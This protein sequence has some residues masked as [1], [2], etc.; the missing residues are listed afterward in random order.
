MDKLRRFKVN[1]SERDNTISEL[2]NQISKQ[3]RYIYSYIIL[4]IIFVF[5]STFLM[6]CATA[7]LEDWRKLRKQMG[8]PDQLDQDEAM[9]SYHH[10]LELA[11]SD[12]AFL[13]QR[14][15]SL[16]AER[17][18]ILEDLRKQMVHTNE[19]G[20]KF[21]GISPEQMNLVVQY[22]ESL[23]DGTNQQPL[24][25][26]SRALA[27]QLY[28]TLSF[29]LLE[30][31]SQISILVCVFSDA[32]QESDQLRARIDQLA[33]ERDVLQEKLRSQ[34]H[35][36]EEKY[37]AI[38][39][40]LS[41]LRSAKSD[42]AFPADMTRQLTDLIST[43]GRQQSSNRFGSMAS[44]PKPQMTPRTPHVASQPSLTA[45]S[46]SQFDFQPSA[47]ND[48]LM[49]RTFNF[50]S[51]APVQQPAVGSST[52]TLAP[53]PAPASNMQ[54]NQSSASSLHESEMNAEA[55]DG[56]ASDHRLLAALKQLAQCERDLETAQRAL[57][58]QAQAAQ[59]HAA[60]VEQLYTEHSQTVQKLTEDK[61]AAESR[62]S[63]ANAT[64]EKDVIALRALRDSLRAVTAPG[65][66]M[67]LVSRVQ[68][69]TDRVS[70]AEGDVVQ[71]QRQC[72]SMES[73]L[74]LQR[75]ARQVA[76]ADLLEAE[77]VARTRVSQLQRSLHEAQARLDSQ[78][79]Q[80][81]TAWV[82]RSD[83]SKLCAQ[84]AS[85]AQR[86][87]AL[88]QDHTSVSAVALKVADQRRECERLNA[89]LIDL[90]ARLELT[91]TKAARFDDVCRAAEALKS[92]KGQHSVN[93]ISPTS[94][95]PNVSD[96]T[97]LQARIASLEANEAAQL[98]R[99]ARVSERATMAQSQL[100]AAEDASLAAEQRVRSLQDALMKER[101]VNIELKRQVEAAVPFDLASALEK[102]VAE[103]EQLLASS[104]ARLQQQ[105]TVAGAATAQ[106]ASQH[107]LRQ[108][109]EA[110]MADLRKAIVDLQSR[111]GLCS[112]QIL[113][114][115][116]LF[117]IY[118][119]FNRGDGHCW[120]A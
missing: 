4:N 109:T 100:V 30:K 25:D 73:D 106:V 40:Q 18:S 51:T 14:V 93:L 39:S 7:M 111:T 94:Q 22:A 53:V 13:Q 60:M 33:M 89:L 42:S 78:G 19:A 92:T 63:E 95:L 15:D 76:E 79:G 118:S 59:Q 1:V 21:Y 82:S 104:E 102:R 81:P 69:L 101:E 107:D 120:Q 108:A 75:T 80:S 36:G 66:D 84:H 98:A 86:Y 58:V 64:H 65:A 52:A 74:K 96:V 28:G 26:K 57:S 45:Q 113:P 72:T 68:E 114:N 103:L 37:Q 12:T 105:R 38:L 54:T 49:T 70:L 50:A 71:L 87:R 110:E 55:L 56:I 61:T 35:E 6:F 3:D 90:E 115:F 83:F 47:T 29:S 44:T 32:K 117:C 48:S 20:L 2:H 9:S 23:R 10:K 41:E 27:S 34:N 62:L 88:L 97:L 85:L 99:T 24:N 46:T 67:E 112:L 31:F 91:E 17:R 119:C 16:E 11:K 8:L 116:I 77:R 43:I 5:N